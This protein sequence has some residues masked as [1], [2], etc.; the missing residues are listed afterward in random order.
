M[1]EIE[2]DPKTWKANF[3][4]AMNSLPDI[5]EVKDKS[6]SKGSTAVRVYRMLPSSAKTQKKGIPLKH[7]GPQKR[8]KWS[9]RSQKKAKGHLQSL[10]ASCQANAPPK[11]IR[12]GGER[13]TRSCNRRQKQ[14]PTDSSV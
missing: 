6:I 11:I 8:K 3:R 4:C 13:I 1:G 2:P 9:G 14:Q 10:P 7:F 12:E 5:E